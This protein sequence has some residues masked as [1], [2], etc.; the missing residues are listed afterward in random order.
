MQKFCFISVFTPASKVFKIFN[1]S[2][3]THKH[4]NFHA[5]VS[6]FIFNAI[7]LCNVE[8]LGES[9]CIG[10]RYCK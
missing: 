9:D 7:K 5:T 8:T 6:M 2:V 4:Y 10:Y 1:N 3:S